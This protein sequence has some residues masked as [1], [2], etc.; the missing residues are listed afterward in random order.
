M[1]HL[2]NKTKYLQLNYDSSP[3][4]VN[5]VSLNFFKTPINS[6][7]GS[8]LSLVKGHLEVSKFYRN[9]VPKSPRN[10]TFKYQEY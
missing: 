4:R 5:H 7:I 2:E 9:Q 1:C 6:Q 8:F 10:S 3:L